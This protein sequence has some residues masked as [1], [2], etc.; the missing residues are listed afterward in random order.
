MTRVAVSVG[1]FLLFMLNNI[2]ALAQINIEPTR[3]VLEHDNRTAIITLSNSSLLPQIVTPVWTDLV[4]AA[5]GVLHPSGK[6]I[7]PFDYTPIKI[8]PTTAILKAGKAISFSV[9]LDPEREI[10]G[11]TRIH[12]RFNVDPQFG[13]GPRW[14]AVIPVFVRDGSSKTDV[15][16]LGVSAQGNE[17]LLVTLKKLGQTSP[18]GYLVVFDQYGR[19]LATLNNVNLF[20]QNKPVTLSVAMDTWP[21]GAMK[22]RYIGDAEFTGILFAEHA[23]QI[24]PDQSQ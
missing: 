15:Q 19:R 6:E 10:S 18:H 5:D 8:W 1:I 14:A 4:Q 24:S 17:R 3:I 13:N 12:L 20:S 7:A 9:L 21:K 23:F 16:I 2:A 22:V 11:E